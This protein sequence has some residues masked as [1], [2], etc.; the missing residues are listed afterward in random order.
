M[1]GDKTKGRGVLWSPFQFARGPGIEITSLTTRSIRGGLE[2][3]IER[4]IGESKRLELEC[5]RIVHE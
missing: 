5:Q 3:R 4:K 1:I 2:R